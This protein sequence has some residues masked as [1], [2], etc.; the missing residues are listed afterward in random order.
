VFRQIMA[1]KRA[2]SH[3]SDLSLLPSFYFP[4]SRAEISSSPL[5]SSLDAMDVDVHESAQMPEL[6]PLPP[7]LDYEFY[8]TVVDQI[9]LRDD[10][11][12]KTV[13]YGKKVSGYM[14][15]VTFLEKDKV[16]FLPKLSSLKF[17]RRFDF[18]V[19][20]GGVYVVVRQPLMDLYTKCKQKVDTLYLANP[21]KMVYVHG[22]SGIGKSF[23]VYGVAAGLLKDKENRV[24]F[25]P[26]CEV[27]TLQFG[28]WP[29]IFLSQFLF[30]MAD[31]GDALELGKQWNEKL[32]AGVP[33]QTY[34]C[35]YL[36]HK[37][38]VDFQDLL[39]SK[40]LRLVIVLD[41]MNEMDKLEPEVLKR[42]DLVFKVLA[43][44][45]RLVLMSGSAN[46]MQL[47]RISEK[48]A[49]IWYPEATLSRLDLSYLVKLHCPEKKVSADALNTI[50]A[51]T[52]MVALEA[53]LF[54][55][56]F[57]KNTLSQAIKLYK[58][59]R[60][61]ALLNGHQR[62]FN[63]IKLEYAGAGAHTDEVYHRLTLA[64][65]YIPLNAVLLQVPFEHAAEHLP[66]DRQLFFY[67]KQGN[68][69][70][71]KPIS[72]L[73]KDVLSAYYL[74]NKAHREKILHERN[75]FLVD[76]FVESIPMIKGIMVENYFIS[77]TSL[78]KDI[79]WSVQTGKGDGD[80]FP[81]QVSELKTLRFDG[82]Y[83]EKEDMP[84]ASS[85]FF[86]PNRQNYPLWDSILFDHKGKRVFFI[87]VTVQSPVGGHV[88][89]NDET[90]HSDRSHALMQGWKKVF[91]ENVQCYELWIVPQEEIGKYFGMTKHTAKSKSRRKTNFISFEG[92]AQNGYD[93]LNLYKHPSS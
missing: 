39:I 43:E 7:R 61:K 22:P 20:K 49:T 81:L 54:L 71:L 48:I 68:R 16:I 4:K 58:E 23:C 24:V 66:Y 33:S 10:Q 86:V 27:L 87:Q 78:F 45:S 62:Y 35:L 19:Q 26:T 9:Y 31:D 89:S 85:L 5:S 46:N 6:A 92:L 53:D 1:P 77:V 63:T 32:K 44:K 13:E 82:L 8:E 72:P 41:Q 28:Y 51:V 38:F 55:N 30:A 76:A 65:Y 67:Q 34:E 88:S 11:I 18:G 17:P 14:N 60:Y 91:P 80:R 57:V 56:Y 36:V 42:L 93:L 84:A 70:Y 64:Q 15:D 12:S 90:A 52:G 74:S 29:A 25:I 47:T 50:A 40:N 21:D 73:V 69:F 59:E 2:R 3:V 75:T 79:S 37:L 83:P